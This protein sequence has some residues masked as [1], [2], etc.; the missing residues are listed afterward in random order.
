MKFA[1]RLSCKIRLIALAA[2]LLVAGGCDS[3]DAQ[4]AFLD[5]A[6]APPAG[7]TETTARGE[8]V[9]APDEDDWRTAPLYRGRVRVSPAFPN[10]TSQTGQVT[11]TTSILFSD[12]VRGGFSV[13]ARRSDGVLV[14]LDELAATAPGNYALTFNTATLGRAGLVRLFVLDLT[15]EIIS[16][17]DLLI[18]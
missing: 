12:S 3:N 5:E 1:L 7:I 13:R 14:V 17:G 15:G 10:P 16:Y 11:L 8:V 9:S 2:V 4:D 18:R 6:A